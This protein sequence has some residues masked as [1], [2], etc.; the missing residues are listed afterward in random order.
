MAFTSEV[1]A[2]YVIF[3]YCFCFQAVV[4]FAIFPCKILLPYKLFRSKFEFVTKKLFIDSLTCIF[5]RQGFSAIKI[6]HPHLVNI[7]GHSRLYCD[8][9]P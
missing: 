4:Y 1:D 9:A 7:R 6:N 5:R 2:Y 8:V 3:R